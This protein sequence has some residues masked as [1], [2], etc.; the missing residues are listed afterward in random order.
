MSCAVMQLR[1]LKK[2]VFAG[3]IITEGGEDVPDQIGR[4]YEESYDE[5]ETVENQKKN[6]EV[7]CSFRNLYLAFIL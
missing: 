2:N 5:N 1:Y 6:K 3:E 7:I 4:D